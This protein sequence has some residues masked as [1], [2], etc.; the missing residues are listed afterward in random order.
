MFYLANLTQC[1]LI[2]ACVKWSRALNSQSRAGIGTRDGTATNGEDFRRKSA[3]Q[4]QFN[5]GQ[6][7]ATWKV[8]IL[9][10][11]PCFPGFVGKSIAMVSARVHCDS[12]VS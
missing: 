10:V 6:T 9:P 11:S 7:T 8:K 1:H 3:S 5:P 2:T 4:V 12:I